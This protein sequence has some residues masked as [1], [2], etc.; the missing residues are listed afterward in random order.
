MRNKYN[1]TTES[2]FSIFREK[3]VVLTPYRNQVAALISAGIKRTNV[4]T[5]HA[6]QGQEWDTVIVSVADPS[7]DYYTNS[8]RPYVKKIINT[9]I[10]RA[11]KR[12]VIIYDYNRWHMSADS[13]DQF[14]NKIAAAGTI[15]NLNKPT[16]KE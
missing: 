5:I 8:L 2:Y 3:Y 16:D 14:F 9:A 7:P 12:L 1:S 4:S 10:S 11:R 6:S 13:D 15:I